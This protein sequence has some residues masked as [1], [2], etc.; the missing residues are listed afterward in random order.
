MVHQLG[1]IWWAGG[2]LGIWLGRNR[3][4]NVVPAIIIAVTG[5]A[6]MF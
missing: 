4:R 2:A 1:V 5:F 6:S 3:K